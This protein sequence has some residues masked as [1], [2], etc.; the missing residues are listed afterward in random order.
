MSLSSNISQNGDKIDFYTTEHK[1]CNL[2]EFMQRR[3]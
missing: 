3:L 1:R 2:Q